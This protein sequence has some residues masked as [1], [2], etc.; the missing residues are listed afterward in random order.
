[1]PHI[2]T[3]PNQHDLTVTAYIVKRDSSEPKALL[4]MHRK[5][6]ILLPIGG[7]VELDETP[8]QAISHELTEESGYS[9]SQLKVLQPLSR[10]KKMT[11]VVQ[12][13]YPLS[14]NTHDIPGGHYHT[15]IEYGFITSEEPSQ[16]VAD[17]ESPDLQWLTRDEL[18]ALGS[19]FIFDNTREIYKFLFDEALTEWEPVDVSNFLLD[20]PDD[21]IE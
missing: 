8:W 5:L 15:D 11:K 19:D 20:Y 6:N 7:H 13:P 21:Y 12:H 17:G 10:I 3:E 18:N 14:M 1:M 2:H 4:H 9:L 16:P